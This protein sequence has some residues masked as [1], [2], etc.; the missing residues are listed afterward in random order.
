MS[1]DNEK[2]ILR[3]AM[4]LSVAWGAGVLMGLFLPGTAAG[5]WCLAAGS[6]LML[7]VGMVSLVP[8]VME[9]IKLAAVYRG[10]G[11]DRA[12]NRN[13]QCLANTLSI[14]AL[15]RLCHLLRSHRPLSPYL[16]S[17][18]RRSLGADTLPPADVLSAAASIAYARKL[19]Q[20][21]QSRPRP[22]PAW[23]ALYRKYSRKT[24][25]APAA[26]AHPEKTEPNLPNTLVS[27]PEISAADADTQPRTEPNP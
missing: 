6:I 11:C 2:N 16:C 8:V 22:N 27:R 5:K 21:R 7:S 15:A 20:C 14:A 10:A 23:Q 18:I 1:G 26:Q 13:A 3:G 17:T 24:V 9:L 12:T 4:N 25:S 19:A